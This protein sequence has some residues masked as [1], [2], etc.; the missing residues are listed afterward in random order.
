MMKKIVESL[1]ESIEVKEKLKGSVD[2]IEKAAKLLV[3]TFRKEKR[4]FLCGNGGS[5]AD[6]QHIAAELVVKYYKRNRKA[7]PALSLAVDPSVVTATSND[8]GYEKVFARQLEA[9]AEKDDLFIALSTSGK[10]P[11]ISE[12]VKT[13]HSLGMRIIYLTGERKPDLSELV[14]VVIMV[15][16]SSTPRIQEA[17]ITIGHL[18]VEYLER[19]LFFKENKKSLF[20]KGGF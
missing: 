20:L 8:F 18:L 2:T 5:A 3:E 19:E 9:L 10:S 17:H 13:A 14:D 16:S 12:A 1:N 7:L 15:P 11:N 6:A 4:V